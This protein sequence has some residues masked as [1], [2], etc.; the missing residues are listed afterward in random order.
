MSVDLVLLLQS[1]LGFVGQ[2]VILRN[3]SLAE[4]SC[5]S[6]DLVKMKEDDC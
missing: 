3:P 6:N 4:N 1:V 5:D 2:G